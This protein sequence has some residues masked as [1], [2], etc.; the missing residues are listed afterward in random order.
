MALFPCG[1]LDE[2]R[3]RNSLVLSCL[4]FRSRRNPSSSALGPLGMLPAGQLVKVLCLAWHL[5]IMAI[6]GSQLLFWL[7]REPL[8][9]WVKAGLSGESGARAGLCLGAAFSVHSAI[10]H[11][12]RGSCQTLIEPST[13]NSIFFPFPAF[14]HLVL[15]HLGVFPG[16]GVR[17]RPN[18]MAFFQQLFTEDNIFLYK[19]EFLPPCFEIR[20]EPC[21][22]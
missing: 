4:S 21:T 2:D 19:E 10:C 15:I 14:Q 1:S 12:W 13:S 20:R 16:C 22:R 7:S 8:G 3:A 9:S 5:R 17:N 11:T 6:L 18:Y